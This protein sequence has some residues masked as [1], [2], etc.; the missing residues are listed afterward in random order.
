MPSRIMK[1]HINQTFFYCPV[2]LIMSLSFFNMMLVDQSE[3]DVY[4]HYVQ[5]PAKTFCKDKANRDAQYAD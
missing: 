2:S 5:S 4:M 3:S 1:C